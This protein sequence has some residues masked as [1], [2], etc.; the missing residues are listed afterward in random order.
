M[1]AVSNI[2]GV[3]RRGWLVGCLTFLW[4]L[5]NYIRPIYFRL[6]KPWDFSADSL[7]IGN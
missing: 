1:T 3:Y 6:H 5:C 7:D 2:S 4:V